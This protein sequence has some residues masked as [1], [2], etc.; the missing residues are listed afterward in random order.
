MNCEQCEKYCKFKKGYEKIIRA[1]INEE[2]SSDIYHMIIHWAEEV[3]KSKDKSA[4]IEDILFR[5]GSDISSQDIVEDFI[6]GEKY[7]EIRN[8]Y[9]T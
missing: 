4:M 3:N 7:K 1:W 6:Y 8:T 5:A 9:D 2:S